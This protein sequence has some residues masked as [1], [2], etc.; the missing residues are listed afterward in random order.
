MALMHYKV[1]G[2]NLRA[3][4]G[5]RNT[6][7]EPGSECAKASSSILCDPS[8][9]LKF[10]QLVRL[11]DASYLPSFP[12]HLMQK[13]NSVWLPNSCLLQIRIEVLIISE[14]LKN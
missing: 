11:M 9:I 13:K 3:F 1:A 7:S 4:C 10:Y 6:S 5:N 8:Q 2:K 14:K 12:S